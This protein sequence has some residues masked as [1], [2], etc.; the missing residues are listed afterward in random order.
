MGVIMSAK[1]VPYGCQSRP[2]RTEVIEALIDANITLKKVTKKLDKIFKREQAH[3]LQ[4]ERKQVT[5]V[6]D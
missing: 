4:K 5:C 1:Y 3:I 6:S 2:T